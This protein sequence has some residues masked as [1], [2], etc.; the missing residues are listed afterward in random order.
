MYWS[1]TAFELALP[2]HVVWKFRP[3]SNLEHKIK[4][5]IL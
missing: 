1:D 3:C 2:M 5:S 4:I